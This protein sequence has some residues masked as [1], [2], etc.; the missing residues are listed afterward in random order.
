MSDLEPRR[1]NALTRR[2]REQRAYR[3]VIATGVLGVVAVVGAVL[4][5]LDI[6]GSSL[7]IFAAVLA[8]VCFVLLRQTIGGG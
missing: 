6:V 1:G 7:A 4:A 3:L 2:E 8:V 5:V